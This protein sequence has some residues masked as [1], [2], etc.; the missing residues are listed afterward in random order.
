MKNDAADNL[1]D[2]RKMVP[3]CTSNIPN[4][5]NPHTQ[6]VGQC[7]KGV[8]LT[9]QNLT[10]LNPGALEV[11]MAVS[12]GPLDA[13]AKRSDFIGT[14]SPNIGAWG[15]WTDWAMC[16]RGTFAYG[17]NKR[18]E[19][20]QGDGDDTALNWVKLDCRATEGADTSHVVEPPREYQACRRNHSPLMGPCTPYYGE[21][22]GWGACRRDEG[23]IVS[24]TLTNEQKQGNKTDD[25]GSNDVSA[26]CLDNEL[27]PAPGTP[28]FSAADGDEMESAEAHCPAGSAVCGIRLRIEP[29]QYDGDDTSMN[30][31]DVACCARPD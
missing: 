2:L 27:M 13:D 23:P 5:I 4:P 10:Y 18:I 19:D 30:D 6:E 28:P 21:Y 11:P 7:I 26:M 29:Y 17:Y 3:Y 22:G 14:R 12:S 25:S 31:F 15:E 20:Y 1:K 8:T 9:L 16:P 24:L